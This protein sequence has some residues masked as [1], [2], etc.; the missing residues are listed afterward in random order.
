MKKCSKCN[1][2]KQLSDFGKNKSRGN[3]LNYWC[4]ICQNIAT[5]TWRIN[6]KE[7]TRKQSKKW[8]DE[9]PDYEHNRYIENIVNIRKQSALWKENNKIRSAKSVKNYYKKNKKKISEYQ[10]VYRKRRRKIDPVFKLSLNLRTRLY[11]AL[12]GNAKNGSAIKDLGCSV[13][14]LKIYLEKQFANGMT[15]D[16]WALD[17]W[18]IDHIIPLSSFDL[19]N[20]EQMKQACH[21]TNLQPLWAKDN[22][23]KSNRR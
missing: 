9:H 11:H 19:T 10:K 18:H 7:Y 21:Y 6:N 14:E 13:K 4:K 23:S 1:K 5:K 12:N 20:M 15:W 2:N 22:L 16:N 8:H 3:G 17:G